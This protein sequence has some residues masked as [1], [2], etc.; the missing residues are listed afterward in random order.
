MQKNRQEAVALLA[1]ETSAQKRRALIDELALVFRE[2]PVAARR[3]LQEIGEALAKVVP[4]LSAA[5]R[6]LFAERIAAAREAPTYLIRMLA[7]DVPE[8]ACPVLAGSPVLVDADLIE[9]AVKGGSDRLAAIARRASLSKP[10]QTAIIDSGDA[11]ALSA[12]VANKSVGLSGP[13][14]SAALLRARKDETI[15]ELVAAR[16]DVP[17][18]ALSEL[19]FALKS[20]A[21]LKLVRA[22]SE[23]TEPGARPIEPM[24]ETE[25]AFLEAV[26]AGDRARLIAVLSRGLHLGDAMAERILRDESCDAL[27]VVAV[28]AGISR[29]AYSTFVVLSDASDAVNLALTLYERYP[30]AGA[31]RLLTQWQA[32]GKPAAQALPKPGAPTVSGPPPAAPTPGPKSEPREPVRS[33]E[34]RK[35]TPRKR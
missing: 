25:P 20:K 2:P 7:N 17:A 35:D 30:V 22:L 21:R 3:E 24:P 6:A 10:L 16:E 23:R 5:E 8:V 32:A 1:R 28:G 11:K 15:A 26:R 14:L 29:S 9:S 18:G 31:R 34:R 13:A 19:F 4:T 27:A 12:L 33:G